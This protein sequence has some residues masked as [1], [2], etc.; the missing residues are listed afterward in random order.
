MIR[1]YKKNINLI[2][3]SWG[4][5]VYHLLSM[6]LAKTFLGRFKILPFRKIEKIPFQEDSKSNINV[7]LLIWGWMGP[8][9]I[10]RNVFKLRNICLRNLF[11]RHLRN[12]FIMLIAEIKYFPYHNQNYQVVLIKSCSFNNFLFNAHTLINSF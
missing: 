11:H 8:C 12:H 3:N 9:Y 10:L 1:E 2:Q 7:I 6:Q 5:Q 4:Y